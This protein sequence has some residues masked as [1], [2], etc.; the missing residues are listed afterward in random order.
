MA[1]DVPDSK[2]A[3]VAADAAW[4]AL[5]GV[6]VY[7]DG[8][9]FR[10]GVGAAAI[11]LRGQTPTSKSLRAHLG[12]SAQHTVYESELAGV[13]LGL[14]MIRKEPGLVS[15]A[16]IALD[17]KAAVLALR[18]R[19]STPGHHLLDAVHELAKAVTVRHPNIK[20]TVRWVPGHLGVDG[21]EL[22]DDEAKKAAQKESSPSTSLPSYL[23]NP[24]LPT[25]VSKLRQVHAAAIAKRADQQWRQSKRYDKTKIFDTIPKLCHFGR[26]IERLPRRHSSLIFQ[27]RSGRSPLRHSLYKT[28]CAD[29]PLCPMCEEE[30]ETTVHFFFKCP[31][32]ARAR[33]AL[34]YECGP[35][36]SSLGALLNNPR[37]QSA[38]F[39]YIHSTG[40][41]TQRLG[42]LKYTKRTSA[43]KK[44]NTR[45]KRRRAGRAPE[46]AQP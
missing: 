1:F 4:T 43:N 21:N 41:F 39:A 37:L 8:S 46:E 3:A 19:R 5:G 20:L 10:G 36:A 29:S 44:T 2:D 18:S 38:V 26:Y 31:A 35:L 40:R 23:R 25:S 16:S 24:S 12:T 32:Y 27:L 14:H 11:L 33:A 13:L 34:Y 30:E 42:I 15:K 22:A 28:G 6:R 17:N 45:T 9:D 7:S